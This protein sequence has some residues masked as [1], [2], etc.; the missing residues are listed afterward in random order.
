MNAGQ[1]AS[2]Y[3]P[4]CTTARLGRAET[5]PSSF[6]LYLLRLLLPPSSPQ[7]RMPLLAA[8]GRVR[9]I[10]PALP[11]HSQTEKLSAASTEAANR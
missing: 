11:P 8:D 10:A 3:L 1:I 6:L 2:A 4:R 5:C 7:V 9:P